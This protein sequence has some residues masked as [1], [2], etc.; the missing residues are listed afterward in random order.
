[1][2]NKNT[3][4]YGNADANVRRAL[5]FVDSKDE[6]EDLLWAF[7]VDS[8]TVLECASNE[9]NS[10]SPLQIFSS[11][12]LTGRGRFWRRSENQ[13]LS[14]HWAKSWIRNED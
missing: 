11:I 8:G 10:T 6:L 1:M 2:H 5:K 3:V 13:G 9:I 4:L 12:C 14:Y 7:E